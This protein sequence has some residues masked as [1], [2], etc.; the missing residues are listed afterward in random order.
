MK[1]SSQ[2]SGARVGTAVQQ[3]NSPADEKTEQLSAQDSG[4]KKIHEKRTK[5]LHEARKT[6]Q[7]ETREMF[8]AQLRRALR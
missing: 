4:E 5:S 2:N 3:C 6:Q 8:A 7:A 1:M